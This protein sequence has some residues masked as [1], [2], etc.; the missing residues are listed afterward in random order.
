MR[1]PILVT[2]GNGTLGRGVVA[3]LLEAGHEVL[4]LSRH[5]ARPAYP[6]GWGG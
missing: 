5:P 1:Q 3:R 2:S 4:V 6:L